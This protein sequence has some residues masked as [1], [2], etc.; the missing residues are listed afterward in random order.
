M[1]KTA[2]ELQSLEEK[3]PS[4]FYNKPVTSE[5]QKYQHTIGTWMSL[6]ILKSIFLMLLGQV[7]LFCFL[8]KK[9]AKPAVF[10][11]NTEIC[12]LIYLL[13]SAITEMPVE[14]SS[15]VKKQ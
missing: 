3:K 10:V 2:R 4:Q 8:K 7:F 1:V 12:K 6:E 5:K 9:K 14:L 15:T 11:S 13:G